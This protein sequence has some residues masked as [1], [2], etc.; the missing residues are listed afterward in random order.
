MARYL[1]FAFVLIAGSPLAWAFDDFRCMTHVVEEGGEYDL[2]FRGELQE[3]GLPKF[4]MELLAENG[5]YGEFDLSVTRYDLLEKQSLEIDATMLNDERSIVEIRT[6]FNGV[7]GNYQGTI[8]AREGSE[9]QTLPV[10]CVYLRV[11]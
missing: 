8:T 9:A 2:T 4:Q 10:R 1:I 7:K 3:K 5:F 6:Q 11:F